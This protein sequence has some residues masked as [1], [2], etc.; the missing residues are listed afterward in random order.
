MEVCINF[1]VVCGTH[2]ICDID[3]HVWNDF[4]MYKVAE[5]MRR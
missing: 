4:E 5:I 2:M 1:A 3:K